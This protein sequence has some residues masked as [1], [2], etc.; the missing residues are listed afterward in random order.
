MNK[1]SLLSY[2]SLLLLSQQDIVHAQICSV[3]IV[4]STPTSQFID[5]NNGSLT[6]KKTGLVWKKC[7]EG[8]TWN[9]LTGGCNGKT[10]RYSWR[11]ALQHAQTVNNSGGFA[12][13][14]DWRVPDIKA[15]ASIVEPRCSAPTIN[16]TVF[17]GT[18]SATF[19]STSSSALNGESAWRISFKDGDD[20]WK[21]KKG[22][23]NQIRLVRGGS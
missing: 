16:S 22:S 4:A 2:L 15:L 21:N 19:W 12:G 5:H 14:T 7:S 18:P 11:G 17:P 3:S 9:T 20:D 13:S 23:L 6:D 1:R 8:Q 10:V